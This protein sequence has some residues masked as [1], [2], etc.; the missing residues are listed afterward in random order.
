MGRGT[1]V[2]SSE[3]YSGS[4]TKINSETGEK[5]VGLYMVDPD[6]KVM[7]RDPVYDAYFKGFSDQYA[8]GLIPTIPPIFRSSTGGIAFTDTT[9]GFYALDPTGQP[10]LPAS[11]FFE[12]EYLSLYMPGIGVMLEYYH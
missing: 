7:A 12:G 8:A 1:S 5:T 9:T 2:T 10:G 4:F 3:F 6:N 11:N